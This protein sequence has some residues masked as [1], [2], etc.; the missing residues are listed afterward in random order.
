MDKEL[1]EAIIE[2]AKKAGA[3][4]KVSEVKADDLKGDLKRR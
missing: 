4:V 2:A 3:K 1:L